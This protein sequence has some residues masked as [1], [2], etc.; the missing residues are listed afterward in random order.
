MADL[1]AQLKQMRQPNQQSQNINL[2]EQIKQ[3]RAAQ[4]VTQAQALTPEQEQQVS[5]LGR[6]GGLSSV[7][8]DAIRGMLSQ[9]ALQQHP[10]IAPFARGIGQGL[11]NVP[12]GVS[13][14]L[15]APVK[16]VQLPGT[17]SGLGQ[18]GALLGGAVAS[19]PLFE[20]AGAAAEG[21]GRAVGLQKLLPFLKSGTGGAAV[22]LAQSP[23]SPGTGASVGGATGLAFPL[24]G[25][26]MQKAFGSKAAEKGTE[27][28]LN[29][30]SGGLHSSAPNT[31]IEDNSIEAA[32]NIRD[33]YSHVIDQYKQKIGPVMETHGEDKLFEGNP[34]GNYFDHSDII[35]KLGPDVKDADS[36][37]RATPTL[38]NAHNLQSTI[39]SDIGS[40]VPGSQ[41]ERNDLKLAAR[42]R[43]G[44]KS[45]INEFL[46]DKDPSGN[47]SKEYTGASDYYRDHAVPFSANKNLFNIAKGNTV[48]PKNISGLFGK[49]GEAGEAVTN[50]DTGESD[51][52]EQNLEKILPK[53]HDNFKGRV[54]YD[55]L[56]RLQSKTNPDRFVRSFDSLSQK[57][58]ARNFIDQDMANARDTIDLAAQHQKGFIPK[59]IKGGLLRIPEWLIA[60]TALR[61]GLPKAREEL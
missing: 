39:G 33:G 26:F 57:G 51:M 21:A 52:V 7:G 50:P 54:L 46:L 36:V 44:L 43:N 28:I 24:I 48:A 35:K 53:M 23:T 58:I 10:N 11:S 4:P 3:Q 37:Y 5:Q 15:G 16:Q 2:I 20:G 49:L 45:D 42:A 6:Q 41:Q 31:S 55:H 47:A 22:G 38:Q 32:K 14:L 18:L 27:T 56:G 19:A 59:V 40:S 60:G 17:S 29:K 30:L 9:R 61:L 12:L 8:A 1:L 13:Q 34:Q 25:P